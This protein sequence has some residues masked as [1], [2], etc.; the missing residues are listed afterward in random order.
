[1]AITSSL[2]P[3]L[4]LRGMI[5]REYCERMIREV[6][7]YCRSAPRD[8]KGRFDSALN[9]VLR[10]DG[11]KHPT[12][13]PTSKL[14]KE[15]LQHLFCCRG[16]L[17][18]ILGAWVESRSDLCGIVQS[19]LS[20]PDAGLEQI[21]AAEGD[22]MPCWTPKMLEAVSDIGSKNLRY[23]K[24][25]IALMICCLADV[26]Q[27][28]I[29]MERATDYMVGKAGSVDE[30]QTENHS[31]G[32]SEDSARNE[33]S[34]RSPLFSGWLHDLAALPADAEEWDETDTF[35]Q[36]TQQ[37]AEAKRKERNAVREELQRKLSDFVAAHGEALVFFGA[38]GCSAWSADTCPSSEAAALAEKIEKLDAAFNRHTALQ[39]QTGTNLAEARERRNSLAALEDEIVRALETLDPILSPIRLTL[40]DDHTPSQNVEE[41][42]S[43]EADMSVLAGQARKKDDRQA[44]TPEP[45]L[46]V[47]LN[48]S[49]HI[50]GASTFSAAEVQESAMATMVA[51]GGNVSTETQQDE[52]AL[53]EC[54]ED[55]SASQAKQMIAPEKLE[56]EVLSH[57]VMD[58]GEPLVESNT[59]ITTSVQT[60]APTHAGER[61]EVTFE[62]EQERKQPVY[63]F[64]PEQTAAEIAASILQ[65]QGTS[66]YEALRHL[67]WRL[68]FEEKFG[69]AFHLAS[70]L[71]M[72]DDDNLAP[73]LTSWLP[74]AVTL[75]RHVRHANGDVARL[76]RDDFALFGDY[77]FTGGDSEWDHAM[78]FLCAAAAMRPALLAPNTNASA[79]LH[80]LRMG[81]G[82]IKL[83][84]C[85]RSIANYGDRRQALD[86]NSL[87]KV[88][89][90]AAWQVEMSAL[91]QKVDVWRARAPQLKMYPRTTLVWRKWLEP[92]Q[93][94]HKLLLSIGQDDPALL[95]SVKQAVEQFSDDAEIKKEVDYTDRKVLKRRGGEDLIVRSF[96][97]LRNH[98]H[99]AVNF[100]RQWIELQETRPGQP[101]TFSQQQAEQLSQ[102]IRS[103]QEA[104]REELSAFERQHD[105]FF[106]R[107]GVRVCRQ[108]LENLWT[109]FD[110][111]TQVSFDEPLPQHLLYAELLKSPVLPLNER[112]EPQAK[113]EEIIGAILNLVAAGEVNW[114]TAFD[115]RSNDRDHEA[116]GQIIEYLEAHPDPSIDV[117]E[118]RQL[119]ESGIAECREALEQD[120]KAT[121]KEVEGAVAFGLLREEER[122]TLAAQVGSVESAIPYTLRFDESRNKLLEAR[123]EITRKR[124]EEKESVRQRLES[125]GINPDHPAYER[126]QS[127]LERGDV[128][129]AN[130][131]IDLTLQNRPLP[132]GETKTNT[133][134]CFFPQ[135]Y[136]AI[137][138]FM[139]SSLPADRPDIL[140]IIS[141]VGIYAKGQRR[142]YAI[143]PVDMDRVAGKQAER[144]ARI[145][146]AWFGA[147]KVR[148]VDRLEARKILENLGFSPSD[149]DVNQIGGRTWITLMAEPV[150]D[151]ERCPLPAFGSNANGRYRI[152]CVWDRPTEEDLL[153]YVGDTLHSSPVLVFYFGRMT[154][155]RRRDLARRCRQRRRTFVVIDDTLLLYL[156][157]EPEPRLRAMFE[158]SL[159]FTF[160]EPYTTT[161]GLVPIE[162]FY[163]R[164]RERRSIIDPM[165][166]CFIYGG[167]QLGKTALLRDVERRFNE[168]DG[169]IALWFDLKTHGIGL[170]KNIDDIWGLLAVEL[171]RLGIISSSAS[172]QMTMDR[173]LEH[174]QHWLNE[175]ET[176]RLLLLL[177]EADDFLVYDGS[178][179]DGGKGRKG[180]FVRSAR[181]KGLMDRTH[182]RFKVVF[183]GLHNVQRTTRLANHPLAHYGEPI[184]IGP[185]LDGGE[186]REARDLVERPLATLGYNFETPD[187]VTRILWQT[188]YYPSLIQLYGNHLLKHLMDMRHA[189]TFDSKNSPPYVITSKHVDE[190]YLS[191]DL[192]KAI[193]DRLIWTLQ[194]D[195]RYEVIA[196]AM[197]LSS[198][199]DQ[200]RSMV[201]GFAV[202]WIR[203]EALTWWPEGFRESDSEDSIR[204]LLDEMAGLGIL[205]V[206]DASRYALRSTNV[207]FLMGT[208]EEIEAAL[209]RSREVP[210]QYEPSTF[211]ASIHSSEDMFLRSPLTARQESDLR[212]RTSGI[213]IIFGSRAAGL[214]DLEPRLKVIFGSE[215]FINLDGTTNRAVFERRLSELSAG[216]KQGTTLVL[217][218]SSCPWSAH[219]VDDAAQKLK[220]RRSRTSFVRVVFVADPSTAWHLFDDDSTD[221]KNLFESGVTPFSLSAWH[222]SALRQWLDECR[223]ANDPPTRNK[224]SVVTGRWPLLLRRFYE[225]AYSS[226]QAWERSLAELSAMLDDPETVRNLIGAWG[227]DNQDARRILR[228]LYALGEA[229]ADDLAQIL[230]DVPPETINKR[231]SWADRLNLIMPLG[232]GCWRVDAVVG[233][234][235]NTAG[236]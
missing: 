187:L 230:D 194:L 4:A 152:L 69:L 9:N 126:I 91:R 203:K 227:L 121:R 53:V 119:R 51:S 221:L 166:S 112:W 200:E 74:R 97:Q 34:I 99:E 184:C 56:E 224:I 30:A 133:F 172:R 125:A 201:E 138:E 174:I 45:R 86:P 215:F 204:A 66:R 189:A 193:R 100:A 48:V 179:G 47:A 188:N 206:V 169:K 233:R 58:E 7:E 182:R 14:A 89:D 81:Q 144:A 158:C 16:V 157:G 107:T 25:D 110:A 67:I 6:L 220:K 44:H 61:R 198:V 92:G 143:G 78:R 130:E 191:H 80:S 129:T 134:L 102:E 196:Y 29:L 205:R 128:W 223:F 232:N 23:E 70:Y 176:R 178:I 94:L 54:V 41:T 154:E 175:D 115:T 123:E 216:E 211:R 195:Q 207:V 228:D 77:C 37:L 55:A 153:N 141:D 5:G 63:L 225:S 19:Y 36:A 135:L 186:W 71:E 1:M 116:T 122:I 139:G 118:L 98:L 72:N 148:R 35:A 15:T 85:C 3:Y 103:R 27:F 108:A 231:L 219:W 147:K 31:T 131:Y 209:L 124:G 13:A 60:I 28:Q 88:R 159:P 49:E 170:D 52:D 65:G 104:V 111:E 96:V 12:K 64:A 214:D 22:N 87:K 117:E 113:E 235:L 218:P 2:L 82:L 18:T 142:T 42:D 127:V 177:D 146:E 21:F 75:G 145:L 161:A 17:E 95:P 213:S 38:T 163:G 164:E 180:E 181:L 109:L 39:K 226:T 140:K 114:R 8:V 10:I 234:V 173:F 46:D 208:E 210:L 50:A 73:Q 185:L 212:S 202:S 199:S 26:S 197:A 20:N 79:I 11:F 217:I 162:M 183:A 150:K 151:R 132:S 236:D 57:Y 84:E 106:V 68:I 93:L 229:T 24:D 167:R 59:S 155:Q 40:G 149:I 105:S 222:D 168:Q 43:P 160:A 83:Y 101:Q 165:G 62:E 136:R 76:L 120:L 190:V 156:C 33:F 192:R 171:S 137:N 32:K 90:V